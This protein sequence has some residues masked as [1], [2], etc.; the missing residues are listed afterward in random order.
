ML[1]VIGRAAVWAGYALGAWVVGN[2]VKDE[3]EYY[4]EQRRDLAEAKR[5]DP[6]GDANTNDFHAQFLEAEARRGRPVWR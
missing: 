6:N 3:A 1:A 4:A 5:N 2:L